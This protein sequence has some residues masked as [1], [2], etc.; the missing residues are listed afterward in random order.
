MA[1]AR[2]RRAFLGSTV[3][4]LAIVSAVALVALG[5]PGSGATVTSST[6]PSLAATGSGAAPAAPGTSPAASTAVATTAPASQPPSIVGSPVP[7]AGASAPPVTPSEPLV[8]AALA[9]RLQTR[10]DQVR[11]KA[12]IPGASV[13]IIF[14]D[15]STWL[16]TSGLGYVEGKRTVTPDTVF[17]IA[18]ASKTFLATLTL[19][20]VESGAVG[21]DLSVRTYLPD[22]PIDPKITVRMLLDHTSGLS[23]F[24]LNPKI[25]KVLQ[26][27]K[28]R[29]WT[30]AEAL[31]FMRD[32]VFKPGKGWHYSNTNYV[33]LGL[34]AEAVTGTDLGTLFHQ[35]LFGPLG[36]DHT[37]YQPTDGPT[38][39]IAHGYRVGTTIKPKD[40]SD[41]SKLMP[42]TSV[43][44]AA[45]GAG[46]IATT[47][48]DLA[49][50]GRALYGGSV[51]SDRMFRAMVDDASRTAKF[52][53]YV[54]YGLGVQLM[55]LNGHP[56]LGHSGTLLGFKSDVRFL[57]DKGVSIAVLTNQSRTDPRV[58]TK[59]LLQL[60]APAPPKPTPSAKG[61]ATP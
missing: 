32:Q 48:S 36:L 8:P 56:T 45:A 3:L 35:R 51:L 13:A 14:P 52:H 2:G 28:T 33:M 16:G 47:A 61:S 5:A 18:S 24:F 49:R 58:I 37:Y 7:S 10:L 40:V 39:V 60:V 31:G 22:Q 26:H 20:L 6:A 46:A 11:R 43:V 12:D 59:A 15:G 55:K 23:D 57:T 53:P 34:I 41:G 19:Q 50:W 42:F 25:D 44:T 17:A 9:T 1:P 4:G 29:R 38:G 54:R 21:L 27:D 30:T